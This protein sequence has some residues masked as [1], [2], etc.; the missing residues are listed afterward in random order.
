MSSISSS[1][2]SIL[3]IGRYISGIVKALDDISNYRSRSLERKLMREHLLC[4]QKIL[5]NL[6]RMLYERMFIVRE[7]EEYLQDI[8]K[9]TLN[10]ESWH[11]L[12]WNQ[13]L[14]RL[15]RRIRQSSRSVEELCALTERVLPNSIFGLEMKKLMIATGRINSYFLENLRKFAFP[16]EDFVATLTAVHKAHTVLSK[17]FEMLMH[18]VDADAIAAAFVTV[19]MEDGVNVAHNTDANTET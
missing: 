14:E 7:L 8:G 4:S 19:K 12:G 15:S 11:E 13:E 6:D 18:R 1:I 2:A 3:D 16:T 17:E 10:S 9:N 5:K